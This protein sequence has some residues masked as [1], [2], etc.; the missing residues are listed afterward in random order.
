MTNYETLA[1]ELLTGLCDNE[2][3]RYRRELGDFSHGEMSILTH[4][5]YCENGVCPG[6]LGDELGMTTPR[7]SAAIS[8]LH[9]KGLVT[10][11][12]DPEDRRRIHIYISREGRLLVSEKK[13]EL[14]SSITALLSHLGED[15]A[16]EYIRLTQKIN[17]VAA[18][19]LP[20][21]RS[22]IND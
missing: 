18:G 11:E 21:E 20:A 9:K 13:Q 16:R 14:E 2:K 4:L 19:A 7:I 5:C 6:V 17:R 22:V 10:R 1:A 3:L 15:D 12:S 8:S